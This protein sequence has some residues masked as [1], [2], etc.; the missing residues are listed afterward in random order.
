[1]ERS[2]ASPTNFAHFFVGNGLDRSILICLSVVLWKAFVADARP[3][4]IGALI[5]HKFTSV[6]IQGLGGP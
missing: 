5:F 6:R 1:M 2:R 4:R 3:Y